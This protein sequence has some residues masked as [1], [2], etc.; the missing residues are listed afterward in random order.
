MATLAFGGWS[1]LKQLVIEQ[2]YGGVA[3]DAYEEEIRLARLMDELG[4]QYYWIIEHQ[5]SYVGAITSPTVFLTAVA[6][7]TK[8][9]RIGAMIWVLPFHNPV[10]LAEEVATLDNLSRGR[11]EFG[12]GIGMAQHEFIRMGLDFYQRREMGEEA[13]EI[14]ERAWTQPDVTYD[15]R[16]WKFDEMLPRPWPYQKPHPPIWIAAHS[17]R[18]F[19]WAAEQNYDVASNVSTDD[20]M[21]EK[22]DHYRKVWKECEHPGPMPRQMLVR[23]VHIAETDAKAREEAEPY[24]MDSMRAGRE[25]IVNTRVGMGTH[26][27]GKGKE[28]NR[29]SRANARLFARSR[30]SYDFWIDEGLALI[31]S[32]E[33]VARQLEEK[34]Q[35]FGFTV[36][37]ANHRIGMMPV[38]LVEKSLKLF[39]KGVFPAFERPPEPVVPQSLA[40]ERVAHIDQVGMAPQLPD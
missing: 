16:F 31:G 1:A 12:T 24:L 30:T 8:Q 9:I 27:R 21:V 25:T 26:P 32:P 2:Q 15:G 34:Q 33:T 7:E 17:I 37:S 4:Y 3:A 38:E 11:V 10:R 29:Y 19:E 28:N 22:F 20:E 40:A 14:I 6:R 13:L 35:R 18:A 39:A 5:A 36:F 23:P